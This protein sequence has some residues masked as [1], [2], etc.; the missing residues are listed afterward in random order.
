MNDART[1]RRIGKSIFAVLIGIVAGVAVTLATDAVL[2]AIHLFPPWDQRVPDMLLLLAT[3]YRTIYSIGASYLT[4]R[5]APYSPMQHA[6]VGGAIGFAVSVAGAVATWNGG[7]QFQP[8]W[9]PVVLILLALPCAW[10]GGMLRLK[11]TR[12]LTS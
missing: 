7:P 1:S 12:T 2:H 11:Q 9:Y 8:H 4:A 10:V 3:I 5:L 6:L